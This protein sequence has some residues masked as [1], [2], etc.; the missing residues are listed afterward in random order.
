MLCAHVH[1]SFLLLVFVPSAVSAIPYDR[2]SFTLSREET[3]SSQEV[4]LRPKLG[5]RPA[6]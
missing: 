4:V 5:N 6:H 1:L 3:S 2:Q